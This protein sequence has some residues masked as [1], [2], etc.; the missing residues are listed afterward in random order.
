M[1]PRYFWIWYTTDNEAVL[2]AE[3]PQ[4]CNVKLILTDYFDYMPNPQQPFDP[5]LFVVPPDCEQAGTKSFPARR[6]ARR[7]TAIRAKKSIAAKAG[8]KTA[9]RRA[10]KKTSRANTR[11]TSTRKPASGGSRKAT[12]RNK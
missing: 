8:K 4:A 12:S 11:K 10:T 1:P 9:G 2:F 6:T 3:V 5:S 7:P